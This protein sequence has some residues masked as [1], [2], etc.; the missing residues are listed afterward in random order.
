MEELRGNVQKSDDINNKKPEDKT[1]NSDCH[2]EIAGSYTP[3]IG[4]NR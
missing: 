2:D 1:K 3:D 4:T